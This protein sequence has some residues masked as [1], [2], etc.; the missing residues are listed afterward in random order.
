MS[1]FKWQIYKHCGYVGRVDTFMF[2][3]PNIHRILPAHPQSFNSYLHQTES[4]KDI[5]SA[6]ILVYYT[7]RSITLIYM[8]FQVLPFHMSFYDIN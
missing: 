8:F 1:Y 6:A 3:F 7:L 5:I 2:L 4:Y